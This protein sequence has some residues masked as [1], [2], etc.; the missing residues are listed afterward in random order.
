MRNARM[1]LLPVMLAP[2]IGYTHVAALPP[3]Q[4]AAEHAWLALAVLPL[5]MLLAPLLRRR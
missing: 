1:F 5:V 2:S 3:L 4:H